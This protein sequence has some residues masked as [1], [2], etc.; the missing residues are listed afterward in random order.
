MQLAIN[1]SP[2][3]ADLVRS[4]LIEI[5]CFKTPDWQWMVDE[6]KSLRPVAVHF[7]LEAGNNELGQVDWKT[8]ENLARTTNTPFI[9]LHLDAKQ[10]NFPWLSVNTTNM[11]DID[12]VYQIILSDVTELVKRFGSDRIIIENSPYHEDAGNTLRLCVEPGLISR[13]IEETGCGL[14][15]DI[16]HAI[17]TSIYLGMEP[18]EYLSKLPVHKLKEL[19]FAG[20]HRINHRWTDHLS[21]LKRNWHWL[22]SV[23]WHIRTGEWSLPWMLAFEYGGVGAEFEWR[24][25]AE[26]IL[27]QVP[28]L[29]E[30]VKSASL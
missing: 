20:I 17:I 12:Y 1:Y 15:L 7:N 9:N 18:L 13:L 11:S 8:V 5:D 26:V 19:H 2:P 6:A 29:L 27:D 23:L 10:R 4:G 22:D 25:K 30:R 3:A 28:K 24:S 14:L 21:I 16:S